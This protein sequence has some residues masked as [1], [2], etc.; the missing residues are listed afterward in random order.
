[1]TLR[2]RMET[3]VITFGRIRRWLTAGFGVFVA[4]SGILEHQWLG[5][6]LGA[7][8]IAYGMFAPT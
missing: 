4:V 3:S 7:V 6:G 2:T 8:I 1:M 5:L